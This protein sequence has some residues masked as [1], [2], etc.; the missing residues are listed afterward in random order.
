[1]HLQV[2]GRGRGPRP[3]LRRR[4][5]ILGGTFNPPHLAHLVCAQEAHGQLDLDVVLWIPTNVPPHKEAPEDPGGRVRLALC[6]AAI[7][8]DAR[9][10]VSGIE[11][12][13]AGPSYTVDTLRLLSDQAP[14]DEL[15]FIAGGDMARSLPSWREPEQVLSM[16]TFAVAE[17]AGAARRDIAEQLHALADAEVT[18]FAM[19]R[20][21][22]SSSDV[23]RR[24]AEGRPIRYLV[25]DAVAGEIERR[26][27]YR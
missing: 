26:G 20:I 11:L 1:V 27:L 18:F 19:P 13:R 4:T 7:A 21:D 16:A 6:E 3:A 5:G 15:I 17:R 23:R 9:F 2:R 22:I 8:D 14:E 25:P 10:E 12:E 24:V